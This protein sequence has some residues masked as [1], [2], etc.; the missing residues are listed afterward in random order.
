MYTLIQ[1]DIG[2]YVKREVTSLFTEVDL[3]RNS[4]CFKC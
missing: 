1:H 3:G 2:V 4:D